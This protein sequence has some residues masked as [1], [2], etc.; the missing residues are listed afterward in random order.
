MRRREGLGGEMEACAPEGEEPEAQ[1]GEAD[2]PTLDGDTVSDAGARVSR[3]LARAVAA[4][5]TAAALRAKTDLARST[6]AATQAEGVAVTPAAKSRPV[7]D[8]RGA[9]GA[10]SVSPNRALDNLLSPQTAGLSHRAA[11]RTVGN[12]VDLVRLR[13][14][15]SL[16][17]GYS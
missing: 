16:P 10:R 6:G 14:G 17:F 11:A 4:K 1:Q 2:G 9:S 5:E 12:D 8:R 15:R 13:L 3:L 7:A